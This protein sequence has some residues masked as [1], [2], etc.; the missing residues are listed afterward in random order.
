M[1]NTRVLRQHVESSGL[2]YKFLAANLGITPY[3]LQLKINNHNEFKASEIAALCQILSL[4]NDERDCIFF[5][6]DVDLKSTSAEIA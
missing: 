5:A 3:G 6:T 1:T 2:K 4:T